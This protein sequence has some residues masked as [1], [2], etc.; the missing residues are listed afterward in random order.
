MKIANPCILVRKNDILLD[1]FHDV[2]QNTLWGK[3]VA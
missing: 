3:R 1:Y 2:F